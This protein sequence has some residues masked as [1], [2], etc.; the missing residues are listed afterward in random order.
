MEPTSPKFLLVKGYEVHGVERRSS[1]FNAARIDGT[2]PLEHMKSGVGAR[3]KP[4]PL[5]ATRKASLRP[6]PIVFA[7]DF[8][9]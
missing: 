6:K 3:T 5:Y 8:D 7:E 2:H 9:V 1:L 4:L